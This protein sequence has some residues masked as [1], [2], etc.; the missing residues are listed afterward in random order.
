MR[1]TLLI[2]SVLVFAA[3]VSLNISSGEAEVPRTS[4]KEMVHYLSAEE[5]LLNFIGPKI[6]EIV[7]EQYGQRKPWHFVKVSEVKGIASVKEPK[8]WFEVKAVIAVEEKSKMKYDALTI[9]F[10]NHYINNDSDFMKNLKNISFDLLKYEKDV[11]NINQ[12]T[13]E[14]Q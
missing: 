3:L 4:K 11:K 6:E 14:G 1:R 2:L 5:L 7:Q 9:K 10:D 13:M 12:K 8:D